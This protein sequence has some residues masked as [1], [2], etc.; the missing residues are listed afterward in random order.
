MAKH[1]IPDSIRNHISYDPSSGELTYISGKAKGR[2]AGWET[3]NG[4]LRV[5]HKG[6]VYMAHRVCWFLAHGEQ[7]EMI[8]H[9]NHNGADNRLCNLS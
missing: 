8:D 1:I 4:Y 3:G 2:V 9:L 5:K 7:P 6:R